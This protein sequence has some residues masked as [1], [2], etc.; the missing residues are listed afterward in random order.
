MVGL[1]GL[2]SPGAARLLGRLTARFPLATRLI[3]IKADGLVLIHSDTGTKA[4]KWMPANSRPS[5]GEVK[6]FDLCHRGS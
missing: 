6:Q 1:C 5:W 3:M 2:S 4:L